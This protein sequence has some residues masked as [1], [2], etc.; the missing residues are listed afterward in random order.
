[1]TTFLKHMLLCGSVLLTL[2]SVSGQRQMLDSSI[3]IPFIGV[4]CG[5]HQPQ[6]DLTMKFGRIQSIGGQFGIKLKS[7]VFLGFR[8]DYLFSNKVN[9]DG[10]LDNIR[11]EE[12]GIIEV[13]GQLTNPILDMQGFSASVM[14]GY[15][16]PVFGPNPNSGFLLAAGPVFFQHHIKVDYRDAQLPQLED[17]YVQAYDRLTNGFGLNEF[18]GY[19]FFSRRKLFNVYAGFDFMQTWTK[20]KRGYIVEEMRSDDKIYKDNTVGFRIGWML[21][22]YRRAPMEYYYR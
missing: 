10:V 9:Y 16:L 20:N 2:T 6:A 19:M 21:T 13:G 15:L 7:N 12:G 1:M 18:V 22:L 3:T 14:G 8:M 4:S 17:Q 5:I 11:T